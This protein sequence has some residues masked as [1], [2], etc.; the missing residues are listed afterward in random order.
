MI[1][2]DKGKEPRSLKEYK[3]D[4]SVRCY[5][6]D[7]WE[8][9]PALANGLTLSMVKKDV[10]E[11][12]YREQHGLCAYCLRSISLEESKIEHFLPRSRC[13]EKTLDYHNLLLCCP[14]RCRDNELTC[15]T[16]KHNNLLKQVFNPADPKRD[17]ENFVSYAPPGDS[18]LLWAGKSEPDDDI[19][20]H[21]NL[22]CKSLKYNREQIWRSFFLMLARRYK[23]VNNMSIKKELVHLRESDNPTWTPYVGYISFRLAHLRHDS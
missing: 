22:N 4:S 20:Q 18:S 7:V 8:N 9:G 17:I 19:N 10:R 6:G 12:L 21:L 16:R 5:E 14:G 2:I 15:D 11:A 3:N 1:S 13:P 23:N